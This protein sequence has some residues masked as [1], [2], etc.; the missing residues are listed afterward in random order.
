M[1]W[2][3]E[4]T[5]MMAQRLLNEN[6]GRLVVTSCSDQEGKSTLCKILA[7]TFSKVFSREVI[8]VDLNRRT[9]MSESDRDF[10]QSRQ[11]Q[12]REVPENFDRLEGAEKEE[13]V[14]SLL[15]EEGD[16]ILIIE[17][18][19]VNVFNKH[20]I[21]PA[22]LAGYDIPVL[23]VVNSET[24][25]RKHLLKAKSLFTDNGVHFLGVIFNHHQ[26]RHTI[27]EKLQPSYWKTH[28]RSS[29]RGLLLSMLVVN[30]LW[31]TL[32]RLI[33][34]IRNRLHSEKYHG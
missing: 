15:A 7:D 10:Y 23:I 16:S 31:K 2:D 18:S 20:N 12:V 33:D 29:L 24:T 13:S 21:H 3:T 17:T 26:H 11:I 9:P 14:R 32:A 28:D 27:W 22:S 4:E 30:P 19:P 1:F 5:R 6:H 8:Y 34:Q 25:R